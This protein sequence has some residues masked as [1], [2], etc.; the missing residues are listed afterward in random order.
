MYLECKVINTVEDENGNQKAKKEIY[1]QQAETFTEAEAEITGLI[2]SLGGLRELKDLK[3]SNINEITIA[4]KSGKEG[5]KFFKCKVRFDADKPFS[6]VIL[7]AGKD[8]KA[9]IVDVENHLASATVPYEF[10]SHN[11][12][13]IL[14]VFEK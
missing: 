3:K 11:E 1:L 6:S 2:E 9:A 13:A 4:A 14:E 8:F 5:N 12:S 10:V 7:C